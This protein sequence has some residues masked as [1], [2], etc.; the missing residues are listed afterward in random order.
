MRSPFVSCAG[1][2]LLVAHPKTLTLHDRL[3]LRLL[4]VLGPTLFVLVAGV[5][6]LL[7]GALLEYPRSQAGSLILL[8]EAASTLSIGI[9][10]TLL[11][12]GGRPPRG[13]GG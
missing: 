1:V 13:D 3:G 10:L 7:G 12:A 4:L 6:M 8:I 2:L 11:F 9:T 5:V